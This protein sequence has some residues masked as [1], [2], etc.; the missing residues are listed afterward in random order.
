M[1]IHLKNLITQYNIA[2]ITF[3]VKLIS[4]DVILYDIGMKL[5]GLHLKA[6]TMYTACIT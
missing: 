5:Y 1:F 3:K 4:V 6:Q 2:M